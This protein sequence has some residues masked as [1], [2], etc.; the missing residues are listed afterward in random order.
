MGLSIRAAA[1]GDVALDDAAVGRLRSSISGPLLMQGSPRYD[2]ARTV[3]NAMIDRSPALI[4]QCASAADVSAAVR[5][6][7]AHGLVIAVRG[8]GHNTPATPSAP[9]V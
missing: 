6:A 3:W 5:F 7:S 1:G 8:G 4:V 9:A 2:A